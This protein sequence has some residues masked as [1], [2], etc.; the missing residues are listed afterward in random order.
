MY[1]FIVDPITVFT[2]CKTFESR[3]LASLLH[4]LLQQHERHAA[5]TQVRGFVTFGLVEKDR[6][7]FESNPNLQGK[8]CFVAKLVPDNNIG[9]NDTAQLLV[10]V[11]TEQDEIYF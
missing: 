3:F 1:I 6:E 11:V 8:C 4:T 10:W 2:K 9:G 7:I 5:R